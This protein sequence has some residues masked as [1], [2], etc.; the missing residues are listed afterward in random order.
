V[1]YGN[2]AKIIRQYDPS[3]QAWVLGSVRTAEA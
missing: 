1:L 2:P 3:K